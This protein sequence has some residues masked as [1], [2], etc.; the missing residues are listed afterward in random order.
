ML[1]QKKSWKLPLATDNSKVTMELDVLCDGAWGVLAGS[2]TSLYLIQRYQ[3]QGEKITDIY[4]YSSAIGLNSLSKVLLQ[5][6]SELQGMA[7]A[8][9]KTHK[10]LQTLTVLRPG[11]VL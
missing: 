7:L 11:K 4:L 6:D 9:K 1:A 5:V 2:A 8:V 3:W 10:A